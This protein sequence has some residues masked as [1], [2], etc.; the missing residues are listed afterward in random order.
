MNYMTIENLHEVKVKND[1]VVLNSE[2]MEITIEKYNHTTEEVAK[3]LLGQAMQMLYEL[4][5]KKSMI[6]AIEEELC[7][8]HGSYEVIGG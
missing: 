5:D 6:D 1:K 4:G 2:S 3:E 8:N 7:T